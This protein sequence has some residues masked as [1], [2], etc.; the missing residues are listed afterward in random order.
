MNARLVDNEV[1]RRDAPDR[2]ILS[3]VESIVELLALRHRLDERDG[4]D[5]AT[6]ISGYPGSPLGG[7]DLLL[8]S[9]KAELAQSRITHQPGLNEEIGLT[10]AWGSQMGAVVPYKGVDGVV[11]AWFGKTPGLDRCGDVLRH[12]NAMGSGPNGGLVMFCGD[13]TGSKSSTLPGESLW[14]FMDACVPVLYPADQQD[15]IDFGIHAF[16]MSR[17]AG[18][19]VGMKIV[20]AIADGTGT[21]DLDP[22]RHGPSPA[23]TLDVEG[24]AWRHRPLG[25]IGT[26]RVAD[27]EALVFHHRIEAAKAYALEHRLDRLEG[28]A[29]AARIGIV[30]TGKTFG[31]LTEALASAGWPMDRLAERGIAVLRLAMPYPLVDSV[32]ADFA[33][34][35]D[36]VLVVEEKRPFIESQLRHILHE[37][38]I[39][40]TVIGKRDEQRRPLVP[41]HG[42]LNAQIIADILSRVLPQFGIEQSLPVAAARQGPV[43]AVRQGPV[44]AVRQGDDDLPPIPPRLPSYCSGCP[45]NRSTVVPDGTL[46]GG[47]IGCH[48][49]FYFESR[50]ADAR[51][52]PPPPMGLE[53]V[54]WIGLSAYVGDDHI[55]QNLGDGT[56]SH[57]GSLAIR[58][59]VAAG[60][61]TTFKILYNE[62]VAMTGGQR[63]TGL[64]SV[65]DMTRMLEAEGVRRIIVCAADT[66]HYGPEAHFAQN[67]ELRPRSELARSQDELRALKGVTAIIY[68]QRCATEARRM[69][70]RGQLEMPPR[71]VY[72]NP[73][74]CEGCGDCV[75]KSNCVSVE[76]IAT[77]FGEKKQ[78]DQ[79][80]CNRDYTCLEGDCPSFVTFIPKPSAGSATKAGAETRAA[81]PEFPGGELPEPPM[82]PI[83]AS[84]GI[85]FTGIGGSGTVTAMR[86]LADAANIAGLFTIGLDQTGLA[87]KGGAVVS[88]LKLA[89]SGGELGA[90]ALGDG[91]AD[92]YL[93]GDILQAARPEHLRRLR[94]AGAVA[95]VEGALTP[96]S[97]MVG[98]QVETADP[99]PLRDRIAAHAGAANTAIVDAK[100]ISE[101]VFGQTVFANSI[102]LGAAWQ[103]AALPVPLAAIEQAMRRLG[104]SEDANRK[105]FDWGRWLIHDATAAHA[106]LALGGGVLVPGDPFAPTARAQADAA[107]LTSRFDLPEPLA[108]LLA[109]R[110]AQVIDYQDTKLARRFLALIERAARIDEPHTGWAMARAVAEAW[111]RL[112]TC[113]D[114]YE[115]ARLHDRLDYK[116]VARSIGIEGDYELRFHI[117]PDQLRKLGVDRKIALG[118]P[119]RLAWS[120][121]RRMKWLRGSIF[122]PFGMT[123]DRRMERAVAE[124]FERLMTDA[125]EKHDVQ[126]AGRIAQ[127]VGRVRG[128][129]PVKAANVAEWRDAV[130]ALH[131]VAARERTAA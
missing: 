6:V 93:S 21:V 69:R 110:T 40:G 43:A 112:L 94:A 41:G 18:P 31:D 74:V 96:T 123:A 12:A 107:A 26:H 118:W 100:A 36:T 104:R 109:K 124:E 45:H 10:I 4:L 75:R 117:H 106:A 47:G 29:G 66:G 126:L 78:I 16:R 81:H 62:A 92:L 42:E 99:S 2:V 125:V 127:S 116:A 3:G 58:A 19:V 84:F 1:S 108:D 71:R 14:A 49:I 131:E 9:R 25:D 77:E 90:A 7:V 129:G 37:A 83:D 52:M 60:V 102:L 23:T 63:V 8:E 111:F 87:Q 30:T 54:P 130:A 86:L 115:V 53:G 79:S 64:M 57:S 20:T 59:S 114:E 28:A 17:V 128:Y 67:A 46:I 120:V 82:K 5:T 15:L 35:C 11:G 65:P 89:P 13:D 101:R 73:A 22:E 32:V 38:A 76:P 105:A 56:F 68:D 55:V 39:T 113:K 97:S 91:G 44:A 95:V 122:D 72:I 61:N 85:Y 98:A 48:G 80:G 34:R 103:M 70:K 51:K 119:A 24:E 33:W 88:H 27:Q 50:Q 121:L